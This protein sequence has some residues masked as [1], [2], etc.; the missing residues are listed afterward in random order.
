MI[1]R[2]IP[3]AAAAAFAVHARHGRALAGLAA[4]HVAPRRDALA[5]RGAGAER[6]RE[7]GET[8]VTAHD[9]PGRSDE[10]DER[11]FVKALRDI[12]AA[13]EQLYRG[14]AA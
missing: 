2:H 4:D 11:V 1:R 8:G 14:E 9:P 5:H 6:G 3:E 7:V 10:V 12:A 13:S